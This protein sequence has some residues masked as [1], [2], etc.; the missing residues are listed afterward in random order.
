[1]ICIVGSDIY[2]AVAVYDRCT[3]GAGRDPGLDR[4]INDRSC[5]RLSCDDRV[6]TK[7]DL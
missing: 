4:F 5:D 2:I 3:K 1:M 7:A 6:T